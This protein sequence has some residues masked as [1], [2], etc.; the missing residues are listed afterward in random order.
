LNLSKALFEK[1]KKLIPGGVNSPV[2]AF[3]PYPFFTERGN[4]SHIFDVDGNEYIDYCLAYGPL[5]LGHAHP[6]IVE[7]VKAQLEKGALYGTP[8]EQEVELAELICSV[9]PSA[10]MVRLVSTG[11]E[12]TMSAIRAARG[13]TGKKKIIKFEGCY[14]GAHDYVLVKAGSGATTFGMPTSLGIPEETTQN[15]IVVPFNDPDKFKKAVKENKA[16]L[17]AVIVEP[18]IGN[19]GLVLPREGFLETLREVTENH[20]IVLIFDEVI[21]GFRLALGGA[22]EYYGITPDMT[23]LGKVMGGGFPIAAF[24]GKEE[25][26]KM[27]APSGKVYQAGT[28]SGN[29]ISVIA[30]RATLKFLR[31]RGNEFYNKMEEKC[32]ALVKPLTKTIHESNAKVQINHLSSMFQLFFTETPVYDYATVKTADTA[33]FMKYHAKLLERGVFVPPSQFETCFLSSEHSQ[34]DIENTIEVAK[35][36]FSEGKT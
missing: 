33:M 30:A 35:A 4:G 14:H 24:A 22:Q 32:E 1:A 16:D 28:Y 34:Q 12:A 36:I 15:T 31:E 25:I 7:A 10:E 20:G 3:Q 26:M 13:Y 9:V 23:T 8:T 6:K 17:A 21:T 5:L 11:G 18:V 29:P 27:V 19:I 2:R